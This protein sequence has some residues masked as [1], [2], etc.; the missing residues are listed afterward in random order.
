MGGILRQGWSGRYHCMCAW[1]NHGSY[2]NRAQAVLEAL[3][4]AGVT[5]YCLAITKAGQPQHPLYV[6]FEVASKPFPVG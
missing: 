4:G 3:V 5:P 2:R 6:S 1:G